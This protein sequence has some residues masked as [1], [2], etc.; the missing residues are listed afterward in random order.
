M[1][2]A[3]MRSDEDIRK[4]WDEALLAV[5]TPA[6]SLH[7]RA[8]A[9]DY[10]LTRIESSLRAAIRFF[11]RSAGAARVRR[12]VCL[13]HTLD[14]LCFLDRHKGDAALAKRIRELKKVDDRGA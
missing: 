4:E 10:E 1:Q 5:L 7:E 3:P 9:L 11:S 12:I 8:E 2:D 14:L 13:R 6:P